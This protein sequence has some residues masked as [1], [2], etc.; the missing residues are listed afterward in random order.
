MRIIQTGEFKTVEG[1]DKVRMV[2]FKEGDVLKI[3]IEK[4]G[5]KNAY[6]GTFLYFQLKRVKFRTIILKQ[7]VLRNHTLCSEGVFEV[8]INDIVNVEVI[9]EANKK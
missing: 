9:K 8:N 5:T 6:L 7:M 2:P 1:K 4:E 3:T